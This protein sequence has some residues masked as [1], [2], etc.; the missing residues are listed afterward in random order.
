MDSFEM[1]D[2]AF[3]GRCAHRESQFEDMRP[4]QTRISNPVHIT[5]APQGLPAARQITAADVYAALH[6]SQQQKHESQRACYT[7]NPTIEA[8]A[9]FQF[10]GNLNLFLVAHLLNEASK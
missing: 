9:D 8:A 1:P 4:S 7:V 10:D 3:Y 2:S 5:P 6:A